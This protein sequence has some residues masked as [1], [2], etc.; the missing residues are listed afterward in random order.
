MPVEPYGG[1]MDLEGG[2]DYE[3]RMV[4]P[5]YTPE[6]Q[7]VENPLRPRTF[8]EYI[9]QD[10]V[11][12]NLKIY[13]EAA[14][15]RK[16]SLDHVLLYGPPGL[17]KTTLAGIVANELGVNLRITSGPAIEK[18]GDLA[19]LLT[20]LSPGDVLFIDE[21]H[22]LPRTV[23]EILYPAMEDFALDIITGKGQMAA[24]YHLPLPRFTLVGATTR[25]GQLSAPLAGSVRRGAAAGA[26][27][28]PG[29]G[30]NRLPQRGHPPRPDRGRRRPGDCL[31]LPGHAPHRQPAFKA[32]A[33]L[34]RGDERRR[35]HLEHRE[36]RP[37]PHGDRRAGPG[38]QRQEH[39]QGHH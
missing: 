9:G 2:W 11:K 21:V 17:G 30:Q 20:N 6:D 39:A 12:E 14:K 29:A 34:R 31:P 13:I 16:E 23:E 36:N 22:R 32:G 27:H 10:K 37:G 24:S 18:P 3:N 8:S 5:G 7:A 38:R 33:G 1:E 15:S 26:V 25:A 28:P 19:A 4:E 35:H